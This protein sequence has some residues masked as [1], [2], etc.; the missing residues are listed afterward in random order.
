MTEKKK[1]SFWEIKHGLRTNFIAGLLFLLPA[2]VTIWLVFAIVRVTD[3]VLV[4]LPPPYRPE[5]IFGFKIPGLGAIIVLILILITGF[6]VRNY[7]GRKLVQ[8]GEAIVSSIPFVRTIYISVKQVVESTLGSRH[9]SF[10]RVVFLEYP[11]R[12]IWVLGFVSGTARV[13]DS[14]GRKFLYIF[15]PTT[16]NPTS[17]FLVVMPEDEVR[18]LDMSVEE[19]FRLIISSGIAAPL[20]KDL[21]IEARALPEALEELEQS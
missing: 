7:L 15:V 2:A 19:A 20:D 6:L 11:R 17:G 12:G 18:V 8:L 10:K 9:D 16:P 13:K 5:D 3:R 4:L 1:R 21:V 14:Q